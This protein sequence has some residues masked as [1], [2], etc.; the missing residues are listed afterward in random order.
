VVFILAAFS[1]FLIV[2]KVVEKLVGEDQARWSV[3][4]FGAFVFIHSRDEVLKMA[5]H[6]RGRGG[7]GGEGARSKGKDKNS[8]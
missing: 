4:L 1:F 7:W 2:R 8:C 5:S 6:V 3:T